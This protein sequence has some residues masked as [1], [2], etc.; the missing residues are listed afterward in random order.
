MTHRNFCQHVVALMTLITLCDWNV[1]DEWPQWRGPNRDGVSA[2]KGLADKWPVDGPKLLWQANDIGSG[3][4]T[5]SSANGFV[6]F[7]SNQGTQYEEVIAL[8]LTDGSIA[9]RTKVGAVAKNEGPQYPGCRSTPSV[10]GNDLYTL[11]SDG[12]LVC[13]DAKTGVLKWT[14]NLRKEFDG[15]PGM[16]AYTESPLIDGDV[17]VCSPGGAA[18]TVV[19]LNRNDGTLI[20]KSAIPEADKASYSSPVIADIDGVKQYVFYLAKGAAGIDA[21]DGKFLWR[22]TKTADDAAN[23]Q[24]PIVNGRFVYTAATRVGGGLAEITKDQ[25]VP[26]EVYFDKK[27]PSGMGGAVLVDG[28]LYGTSGKTLVC[29][30]Y[31]TGKLQWQDRSIGASA[32]CFADGKLYLHSEDNEIAIVKANSTAYEELSKFTPPNAPERG[33]GKAWTYPIIVDGKLIIRDASTIWCFDVK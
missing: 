4:S 3:Y 19:A 27:M 8:K 32:I 13:L 11:G 10:V 23:V 28:F 12:D 26:K 16:W 18:A 2:E 29:V 17:L 21:A 7:M 31:A 9:W 25:S 24:T 15:K 22:Y 30:E 1:A 6:Y 14:K 5:P 20:W 33:N